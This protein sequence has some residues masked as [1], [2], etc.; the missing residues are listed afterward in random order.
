PCSS[1]T[2]SSFPTRRSSDLLTP[3][4]WQLAVIFGFFFWPSSARQVRGVA[5]SVRR[6]EY[7]EAARVLGASDWRVMLR[8]VGPNVVSVMLVGGRKSTRLNSSYQITSYA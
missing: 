3:N 5:L 8:H 4:T 1:C 6:R 7:V 2:L